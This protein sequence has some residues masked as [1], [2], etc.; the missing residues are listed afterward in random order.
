MDSRKKI[1]DQTE[2]I[3]QEK[4]SIDKKEMQYNSQKTILFHRNILE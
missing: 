3:C 2:F 4:K 1:T